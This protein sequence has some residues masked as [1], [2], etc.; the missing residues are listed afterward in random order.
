MVLARSVVPGDLVSPVSSLVRKHVPDSDPAWTAPAASHSPFAASLR[1]TGLPIV[2]PAKAG[3]QEGR[4][5]A[6]TLE[7]SH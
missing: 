4:V 2:I 6:M 5:V 7:L 3:I 1:Q